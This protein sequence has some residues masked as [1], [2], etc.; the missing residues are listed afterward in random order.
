MGGFGSGNRTVRSK[1]R[2]TVEESLAIDARIFRNMS[3]GISEGQIT[4]SLPDGNT[5]VA[6]YSVERDDWRFVVTLK[7]RC[8]DQQEFRIPIRI[9]VSA[10]NSKGQQSWFLCPMKVDGIDCGRRVANLYLPPGKRYFGCR[11]CHKLTYQSSRD[12]Q[13]MNR[14]DQKIESI[15]RFLECQMKKRD[16]SRT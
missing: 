3:F 2:S 14:V 7:Y 12:H 13:Y 5:A 1:R 8:P 6:G 9:K 10:T 16:A 15:R 4:W 11:I